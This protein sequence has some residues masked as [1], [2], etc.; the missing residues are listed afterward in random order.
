MKKLFLVLAIVLIAGMAWADWTVTI[1][2]WTMST[3][4]NL[5]HESVSI[6]GVAVAGCESI[7]PGAPKTCTT[8]VTTLTN[9][10]VWVQAHDSSGNTSAPLVG[11]L[12]TGLAPPTGPF[13]INSTWVP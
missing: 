12:G 6:D 13:N 7:A 4:A 10:S 1:S 2:G 11:A 8:T 3:D 5:D 9:Q